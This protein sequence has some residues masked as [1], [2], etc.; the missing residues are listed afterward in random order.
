MANFGDHQ[1]SIYVQGIFSDSRPEI[2]TDLSRLESQ[3][4][5]SLSAEAM[6]YI[7]PSTNSGSTAR[8]NLAA[9]DQW[10]LVPQMLRRSTERD[11]SCTI[12][13]TK[14]SAPVLITP[15]G[16]QTLAHPESELATAR[17][18]NTLNL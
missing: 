4:A 12:L 18:T 11:L 8:A 10:R 14:M 6:S 13:S 5:A 7:V 17:A 3:A 1:L 2:T 16:V 15:V 9:F